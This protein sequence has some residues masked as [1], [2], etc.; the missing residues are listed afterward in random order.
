MQHPHPLTS[1]PP[2]HLTRLPISRLNSRTHSAPRV[3]GN[4][5]R[6]PISN[7]RA[8]Q[9]PPDR[10]R[11][12]HRTGEP[13]KCSTLYYLIDLITFNLAAITPPSSFSSVPMP[14]S[15]HSYGT[16]DEDVE[17]CKVDAMAG[18][19]RI[20][21]RGPLLPPAAQRGDGRGS[22]AMR[23]VRLIF[24]MDWRTL[25][26]TAL[27]LSCSFHSRFPLASCC[28]LPEGV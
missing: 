14:A 17:E 19:E 1:L 23:Y 18:L 24:A 13:G 16:F 28:S 3:G 26:I 20:T 22:I 9:P 8:P 7:P 2:R 11:R 21:S 25:F 6:Y 12:A 5:A 27:A 10:H 4:R 15:E